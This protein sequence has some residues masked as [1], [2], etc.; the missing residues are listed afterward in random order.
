ML[1]PR[2]IWPCVTTDELATTQPRRKQ[3]SASLGRQ[4]LQDLEVSTSRNVSVSWCAS[5]SRNPVSHLFFYS[6]GGGGLGQAGRHKEWA[7]ATARRNWQ[8]NRYRTAIKREPLKEVVTNIV[9]PA[10]EQSM[11]SN[12]QQKGASR[13][14]GSGSLFR[15]LIRRCSASV[16]QTR[17]VGSLKF[18]TVREPP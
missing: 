18:L 2:L 15:R 10:K 12:Q 17:H 7:C 9:K 16:Q 13:F 5:L 4:A 1:K 11:Q 6:L 14:A 8:L 3:I